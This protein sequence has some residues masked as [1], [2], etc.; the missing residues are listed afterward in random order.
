MQQRLVARVREGKVS[1]CCRWRSRRSRVAETVKGQMFGR[2]EVDRRDVSSRRRGGASKTKEKRVAVRCSRCAVQG[3]C[4][5]QG[6]FRSAG[7]T[8]GGEEKFG[9][10]S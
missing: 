9:C 10:A 7:D 6:G 8:V 1:R 2:G 5:W 3:V 4:T